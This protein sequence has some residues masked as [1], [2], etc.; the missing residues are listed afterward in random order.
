MRLE[1][2]YARS[3]SK[4]EF[5]SGEACIGPRAQGTVR[6]GERLE[7][8]STA[9]RQRSVR[10]GGVRRTP[11]VVVHNRD[12]VKDLCERADVSKRVPVRTRKWP[13][14]SGSRDL[15]PC[16]QGL[17]EKLEEEEVVGR[18][19][20]GDDVAVL[21]HHSWVLPVDVESVE[22][23]LVVHG[24]H[25][26]REVLSASGGRD[27]GGEVPVRAQGSLSSVSIQKDSSS[28]KA[29]AP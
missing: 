8:V 16:G 19:G 11:D 27:G 10:S 24:E 26:G 29:D 1:E 23:V 17:P 14:L 20:R 13:D 4:H 25:L 2:Q 7:R 12:P 9:V 21:T 28:K 5:L 15:R 18:V 3:R 6:V 22:R